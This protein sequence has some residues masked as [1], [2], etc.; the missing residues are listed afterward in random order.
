MSATLPLPQ[1]LPNPKRTT[2]RFPKMLPLARETL[3]SD[4]PSQDQP[5]GRAAMLTLMAA[6]VPVLGPHLSH[7]PAWCLAFGSI[8]FLWRLWLVWRSRFAPV[9]LPSKWLLAFLMAL[10]IAGTLWTHRTL[11]GRDAGVTFI[12]LMLLLKLL[13]TR[14]KRD[15]V[16]AVFLSYFLILTT[17]FYSQ[18]I[19]T[20]ALMLVSL[21]LITSALIA[22][23]RDA[24]PMPPL[25]QTRL[26]G[27]IILQAFPMMLVLFLLFPR[28][29]GPL[30]GLP[31]DSVSGVSGLSDSM[32]PGQITSL[33][34]SDGVA[35]RVKFNSPMPKESAMYWRGPVLSSFDGRNWR[36]QAGNPLRPSRFEAAGVAVDYTVTM[37]PLQKAW[38]F[39]LEMPTKLPDY[40]H[41]TPDLQPINSKPVQGRLRYDARSYPAYRPVAYEDRADLAP[42]LAMPPRVNPR[43]RNLVSTWMFEGTTGEALVARA[44]NHFRTEEFFY[45][46]EP[47]LLD[48]HPVDEFLFITKRGF[49]EHYASAFTAMMRMGGVPARVVTGYQGGE[50]NPVDGYFTVRQ[51]DAHAW[52]EVWLKGRGWVRVDP[53]S[54]VSPARI[55]RGLAGALPQRFATPLMARFTPAWSTDALRKFK[56]N[57]EAVTNSWNQWVLNYS[58]DRQRETLQRLGMK[59]PTWQEM[60]VAMVAGMALVLLVV[61]GWV[62]KARRER[63]PVQRAWE[64]FCQRLARA[65]FARASAEGPLDYSRRVAA[66]LRRKRPASAALAQ[67]LS[68]IKAIAESYAALRYGRERDAAGVRQFAQM[69][70]ELRV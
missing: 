28:V 41:L 16:I 54:A 37:E 61:T 2:R 1:P 45:T 7:L 42:F 53:T 62:L 26:A 39:A 23:N 51:A 68:R 66:E 11:F 24:A 47:P 32:S 8:L 38:L 14:S 3:S 6:L 57:W 33:S 27:T 13:E 59:T 69:V 12:T 55:E 60:T 21:V 50:V 4:G 64:R 17:F 22:A 67:V 19:G 52:S 44:L 31:A 20:A 65:G 43:T 63:D 25:A 29:N 34:L 58:P 5:A 70:K 15:A 48:N 10:A 35:F 49:C 56:F 36:M 46:F 40:A 30:W 9:K 18:T